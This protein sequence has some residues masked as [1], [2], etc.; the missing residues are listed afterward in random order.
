MGDKNLITVDNTL[1]YSIHGSKKVQG[2]PQ[3]LYN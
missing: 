2:H 3:A 1:Q